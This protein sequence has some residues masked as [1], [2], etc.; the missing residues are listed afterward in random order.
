LGATV[1]KLTK[2]AA[3]QR[4]WRGR[5][6]RGEC[7]VDVVIS[8]EVVGWLIDH[9]RLLEHESTSAQCVGEAIAEVMAELVEST[10]K[11]S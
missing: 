2:A 3:R 1:S 6:R 10:R 11:K 4:R 5:A 9:D 7:V 8:N